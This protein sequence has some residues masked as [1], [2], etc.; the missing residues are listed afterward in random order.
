MCSHKVTQII[1]SIQVTFININT[2]KVLQSTRGDAVGLMA[3]TVGV[4]LVGTVGVG[5]YVGVGSMCVLYRIQ[6]V[7]FITDMFKHF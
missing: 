5:V 4:T 1:Q 6:L 3:H 7:M 2:H